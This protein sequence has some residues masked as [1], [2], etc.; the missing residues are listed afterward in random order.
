MSWC[1]SGYPTTTLHSK[2]STLLIVFSSDSSDN[3]YRGFRIAY[4]AKTNGTVSQLSINNILSHTYIQGIQDRHYAK[5]NG[6]VS[7]LIINNLIT[8]LYT[9]DSGSPTTPR[10]TVRSNSSSLTIPYHTLIYRGFRIA[11]YAKTS[12]TV[13][14]LIVTI[15]YHTLIYRDSGSPTMSRQTVRSHSSSL[16]IFYHT[17]IYRGFKIAYYAKTNGTVSQLIV[18]ISYHTLIYRNSGSPTTIRKTVRS[19]SSS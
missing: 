7:Q 8:H 3:D 1:G 4:Y 2:Y 15:S 10:Q 17:L 5:T 6:T 18:T 12:G 11:Y 16:T 13:S 14:Q 9:G 19:H